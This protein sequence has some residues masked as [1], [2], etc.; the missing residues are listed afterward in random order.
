M[1]KKFRE[2][3]ILLIN[4]GEEWN[5]FNEIVMDVISY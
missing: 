2:E 3:M 5:K 1:K 4:V